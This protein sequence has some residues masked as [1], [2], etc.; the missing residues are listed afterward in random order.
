MRGNVLISIATLF[1]TAP[2]ASSSELLFEAKGPV[3]SQFGYAIA[4][5]GDVNGDAVADF[6]VGAPNESAGAGAV[7][8]MS[9]ADGQMLYKCALAATIKGAAGRAVAS[10]GDVNGDG[11]MDLLIG[12][13]Q[14][15][16]FQKGAAVLCSG[17]DGQAIFY[18]AG[19]VHQH[20]LGGAVALGSDLDLDGVPDLVLG[21]TT[22]S[23]ALG[24]VRVISGA[25]GG[26][27]YVLPVPAASTG[28]ATALAMIPDRNG[29]G[30]DELAIGARGEANTTGGLGK[31]RIFSGVAGTILDTLTP[32]S[33]T[34]QFGCSIAVIDDA[35]GDGLFDLLI[36]AER[37]STAA[38]NAGAV[39]LV[40]GGTGAFVSAFLGASTFD[41]FGASVAAP[42][43][44]NGDG[45]SDYLIGARQLPQQGKRGYARIVDGAT[46]DGWATLTGGPASL[47][48]GIAVAGIGSIDGDARSEVVVG[49]TGDST[50]YAFGEFCSAPTAYG[51][52]KAGSGAVL[53]RL[54]ASGGPAEPGNADFTI[55][56]S[57]GLGGANAL[58][59]LG[60]APSSV[61]APWGR[62]LV[63]VAGPH[64]MIPFVLTGAAGGFGAGTANVPLPIPADVGTARFDV[65][66]QAI[67]FDSGAAAGVS[68]SRGLKVEVC[69]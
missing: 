28:F 48:F 42:G 11:I 12:V 51:V 39:F 33:V 57:G 41:F 66:F 19:S 1:A 27:L 40:S 35:T 49:S 55:N 13:P 21:R 34:D 60:L 46:H 3:G 26:D 61:Q 16:E 67:V 8:V 22:Q 54:S 18:F 2:S 10:G 25:G 20:Q 32:P 44:V 65:Y 29:D 23:S 59:I 4:R 63:D 37:D 7:R 68:H 56:L 9:G 58:L 62:L 17:A 24:G 69:P 31:V 30:V 38:P 6:V 45:V 36:G 52:G 15:F 5:I 43:D 14:S 50:V 53:P 47:E 64:L